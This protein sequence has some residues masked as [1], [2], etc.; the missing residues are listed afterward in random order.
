M[1]CQGLVSFDELSKQDDR[2]WD[3]VMELDRNNTGRVSVEDLGDF[4]QNQQIREVT[5]LL[6][7]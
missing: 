1:N 3:A 2:V 7:I 5:I 4:L 6:L